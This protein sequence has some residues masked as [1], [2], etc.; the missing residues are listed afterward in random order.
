MLTTLHKT[1]ATTKPLTWQKIGTTIT[2]ALENVF[3]IRAYT[4][5][6]DGNII[7]GLLGCIIYKQVG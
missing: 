5:H 7:N 1:T 3:E 6:L 2:P 4:G